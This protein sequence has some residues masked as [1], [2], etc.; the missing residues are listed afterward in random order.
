MEL[1]QRRAP[2]SPPRNFGN[3]QDAW[4]AFWQEPGQSRCVA[5]APGVWHALES[6][7][8]DFAANLPP[9][10]RVLDLGCGAGA[11]ARMI[12]ATRVDVQVTGIDFARIPLALDPQFDLLA[13]TAMEQLP[14]A[15]ACFG[16]AVSQFGFEYGDTV[17][18]ARELAQVA[19]PGARLSF[20]V[21]HV[22]SGIVATNRVRLGVLEAF[23][24]P[25]TRAAFCDGDVTG[26]GS[27][28]AAIVAN[29]AEDSLALE[30]ARALP[31]RLQRAPRERQTIWNALEDALAPERCLAHALDRACVHTSRIDAWLQ[32]LR[33]VCRLE[34]PAVLREPDGTPV[35]WR[36]QGACANA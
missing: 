35:A 22:D 20:L 16:A 18:A 11:V 9:S 13:E 28:M 7:W 4:T 8:R 5:G 23:L 31:S 12:V 32:P 19:A 26:F 1:A 2:V 29:H 6:H 21:H 33:A 10:S 14:F 15:E 27:R 17:V 24:A 25:R 36:I 34:P 30:L 3:T